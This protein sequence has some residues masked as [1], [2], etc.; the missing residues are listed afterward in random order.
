M[1]QQ[2]CRR[3]GFSKQ[4]SYQYSAYGGL[5]DPTYLVR[6]WARLG[7]YFCSLWVARSCAEDY[8]FTPE[9]NHSYEKDPEFYAWV[10]A[11]EVVGPAFDKAVEI[12][13]WRPL[14]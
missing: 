10:C 9:D 12:V 6:E 5:E 14:Q 7:Q 2:F 13:N 1:V 3:Y 11:L 8:A 4:K